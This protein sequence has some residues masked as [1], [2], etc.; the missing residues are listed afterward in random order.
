MNHKKGAMEPMGRPEN[1]DQAFW[2]GPLQGFPKGN[3]VET[4]IMC[5]DDFCRSCRILISCRTIRGLQPRVLQSPI[6]P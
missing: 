1:S 6:L 5:V 2:K 3:I 4:T